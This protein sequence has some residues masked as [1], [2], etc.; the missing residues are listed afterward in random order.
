MFKLY[1]MFRKQLDSTSSIGIS[2]S[3]QNLARGQLFYK[4]KRKKKDITYILLM[5]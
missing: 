2:R 1:I 3:D 4:K 5:H